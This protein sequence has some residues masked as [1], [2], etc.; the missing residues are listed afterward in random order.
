MFFYNNINSYIYNLQN[1]NH[2]HSKGGLIQYD[3]NKL[4]CISGIQSTS[5]EIYNIKDNQ[6]NDLPNMNRSHCD[7]SYIIINNNILYA[8]FGFDSQNKKYIDDI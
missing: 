3:N 1:L 6:W 7:S 8:F 5:V 2:S 4:I